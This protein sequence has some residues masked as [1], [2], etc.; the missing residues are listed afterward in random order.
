MSCILL[1]NIDPGTS[2]DELRAFLAK[3]GLPPCDGI[4]HYPGNGTRPA[5]ELRFDAVDAG[6]LGIFIDRIHNIFW[7]D[8]RISVA[9]L[10]DSFL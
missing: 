3:Y 9:M 7:K 10:R 8:R 4:V 2:D 6:T 5:V 1:T